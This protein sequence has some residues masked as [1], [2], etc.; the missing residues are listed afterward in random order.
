MSLEGVRVTPAWLALRE[1]ADAAARARSLA[2]RLAAHLAERLAATDRLVIHD[3]GA[4]TGAMAR[5]LAPRLPGPQHWVL[6]DRDAELLKVATAR[7]PGPSA[8]GSAVIVQARHSDVAGLPAGALAGATV[9]TASAL[10]DMLTAADLSELVVAC[11]TAGC[12]LLLT[13]SVIGQVTLSPAE[14]VDARLALA[15]DAHQRRITEHGRLLGPDAA[16]VAAAKFEALGA[17]VVRALSPW[18]LDAGNGELISEWLTGWVA[19]ACEQEPALAAAAEDYA[20]RRL[21]QSAAGE[22]AVTVGHAD[23]LVLPGQQSS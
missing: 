18:R 20:A 5:W 16:D 1:P 14:P 2:E 13:L 19:A 22:L 3:L 6:H 9:V 4:G 21:T 11:A 23:L 7:P 8:D 10:L 17:E 12:P 15:F